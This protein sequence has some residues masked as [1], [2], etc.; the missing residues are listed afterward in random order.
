M[1]TST[2]LDRRNV[3]ADWRVGRLLV[4]ELKAAQEKGLARSMAW[5]VMPDHFHWL[6]ELRESE[7]SELV[8]R[9][10]SR[11][12][13]AVNRA[14][15]GSGRIW[16]DGFHDRAVR[17]EEDFLPIAHCPLHRCKSIAG[18]SGEQDRRLPFMGLHLVGGFGLNG[19][20]C[21]AACPEK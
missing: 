7:L 14:L 17:R 9:I 6:F 10:K 21:E 12:S 2:V 18:R 13:I 11:T 20:W 4:A 5:V 8:R 19:Q 16:Q 1:V 15:G 3:F